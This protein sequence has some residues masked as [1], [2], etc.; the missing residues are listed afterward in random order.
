VLDSRVKD[1][2]KRGLISSPL[3]P[4]TRT[5][6]VQC[7][8]PGGVVTEAAIGL[9]IYVCNDCRA[10]CGNPAGLAELEDEAVQGFVRGE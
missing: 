10:T 7:G 8:K 9:I 5:Y 1:P 2:A 6:C 3:G 4:L